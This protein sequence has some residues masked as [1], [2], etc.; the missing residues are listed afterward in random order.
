MHRNSPQFPPLILLICFV[1]SLVTSA[2]AQKTPGKS[3]AV[4]PVIF[5]DSS[6]E[7]D[8][9]V[10]PVRRVQTEIAKLDTKSGTVTEGPRH[11]L[12]VTTYNLKGERVDNVSYPVSGPS[13]TEEYKYDDK[14]NIAEMTLRGSDGAIISREVYTYEMDGVGNWTKMTTSLVLFEDG[15]LRHEPVEATYRTIA[16]FYDETIAKLLDSRSTST[17]PSALASPVSLT[18]KAAEPERLPAANS[19]APLPSPKVVDSAALKPVEAEKKSG[20]PQ[21]GKRETRPDSSPNRTTPSES[22]VGVRA[23][24]EKNVQPTASSPVKEAPPSNSHKAAFESYKTGR[25]QFSLGNLPGAIEAYKHAIELEPKFADAYLS[26]GHA[27]LRQQNSKEAIK[28]FKEATRINPEMDEAQYGL[29]LEYFRAG[30]MKDAATAFKKAVKVN[31]NMAKAHYG[32]ALA[33]QEL[34]KQDLLLEEFRIL[35]TLDANLAKKLSDTFPEFNL[36]CNG[37][38]CD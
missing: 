13:G 20:S 25:E 1:F 2:Q 34:G 30:D 28:A 12:E 15:A 27:Y 6:K 33:Y 32:L 38:R 16:Y 17:N 14:G 7:Q 3:Q 10:G 26:L 11:L 4:A 29:G 19:E 21:P 37:R 35:Q 18:T 8:G 31:P 24:A 9:L 22:A 23:A 36:P 5:L